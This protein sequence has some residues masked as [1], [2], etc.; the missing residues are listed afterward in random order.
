[1]HRNVSPAWLLLVGAL[2]FVAI[3]VVVLVAQSGDADR[4]TRE[5]VS[6]GPAPT[7]D[8][9]RGARETVPLAPAPTVER[10][11]SRAEASAAD[12]VEATWAAYSAG[13]GVE[14]AA[15]DGSFT[16]LLPSDPNV[17]PVTETAD[18]AGGTRYSAQIGVDGGVAVA[19]WDWP[20]TGASY[21]AYVDFQYDGRASCM[22]L[23]GTVTDETQGTLPSGA[24]FY[25]QTCTFDD[26][27]HVISKMRYVQAGDVMYQLEV[28]STTE[29]PDAWTRLVDSFVINGN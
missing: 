21:P 13:D 15:P 10:E 22:N 6:P 12:A 4:S 28:Y 3:T 16:V 20:Q 2:A 26:Y 8:V 18:N 29:R 7:V 1:M 23:D 11:P 14:Y 17:I 19:R 9:E 24:D 27:T 25:E 5:P